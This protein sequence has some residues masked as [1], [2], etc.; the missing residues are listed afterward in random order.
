MTNSACSGYALIPALTVIGRRSDASIWR[1][2]IGEGDLESLDHRLEV[3]HV[4]PAGAMTRNSS[5]P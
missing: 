5:G 1:A 4:S 2:S 3:R